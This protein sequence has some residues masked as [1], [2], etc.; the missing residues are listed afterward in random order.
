MKAN[1][2]KLKRKRVLRSAALAVCCYAIM[3][4]ASSLWIT[5]GN[6]LFYTGDL[7]RFIWYVPVVLI[8]V[9]S[10]CVCRKAKPCKKHQR[11]KEQNHPSTLR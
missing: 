9:R 6:S 7:L 2:S 5:G 8:L 11:R 4:V 10:Q 1:D 3:V